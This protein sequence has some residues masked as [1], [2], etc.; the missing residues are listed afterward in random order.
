[1]LFVS[2]KLVEIKKINKLIEQISLILILR[3]LIATEF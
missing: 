2:L 1:M 3:I